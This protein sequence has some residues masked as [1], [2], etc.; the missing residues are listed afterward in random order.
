MRKNNA[1]SSPFHDKRHTALAGEL[2]V[3]KTFDDAIIDISKYKLANTR[4][5]L[6]IKVLEP[7]ARDCDDGPELFTAQPS[8]DIPRNKLTEKLARGLQPYVQRMQ[9]RESFYAELTEIPVEGN[10]WLPAPREYSTL[11]YC[12]RRSFLVGGQNYDTNREIAELDHSPYDYMTSWKN[13]NFSSNEK[14]QGRCRH[15]A[16]VHKDKVYVFGGSYMYN[17]KRQ[18]RECTA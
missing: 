5:K 4:K 15:S 14:I 12:N 6:K 18:V 17:R 8:E 1:K 9:K 13:M 7:L 10:K 2:T 3:K 16:C 11:C